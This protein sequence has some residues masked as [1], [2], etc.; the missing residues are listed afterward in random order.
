V[1]VGGRALNGSS[2]DIAVAYKVAADV[3]YTDIGSVESDP[4][5]RIDISGT[6]AS[7]AIDF[8]LTLG[9][10]SSSLTPILTHCVIY[11]ALR[12]TDLKE[13][14]AIVVAA[15]GVLDLAGKP[16]RSTWR[17]IRTAMES[18]MT[19]AGTFTVTNPAGEQIT[20]IGIDFGHG[21]TPAGDDDKRGERWIETI[22]MV[23]TASISSRGTWARASAFTWGDLSAFTWGQVSII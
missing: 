6:I 19:T 20:V 16:M 12:T 4:G 1:G 11:A 9:T 3:S 2:Q 22:K 21:Y 10:T 23:Q 13:I 7:A 18:A 5:E 15:D 14:N 8:K 17:D